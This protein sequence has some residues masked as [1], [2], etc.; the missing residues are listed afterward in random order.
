M[1]IVAVVGIFK[2]NA[3][4]KVASVQTGGLFVLFPV[5]LGCWEF[6]QAGFSKRGFFFGLMQFW[7]LFAVPILSLRLLHWDVPFNELSIFGVS[8]QILHRYANPSY[9]VMMAFTFWSYLRR[10]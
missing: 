5:F 10:S 3:N 4:M 2:L 7:I 9:M 8:G 6:R 1:M